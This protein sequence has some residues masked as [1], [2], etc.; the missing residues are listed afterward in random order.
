MALPTTHLQR[1]G[2][3]LEHL[4]SLIAMKIMRITTSKQRDRENAISQAKELS[5]SQ[6]EG[7]SEA[8]YEKSNNWKARNL[9]FSR[10]EQSC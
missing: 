6:W 10:H 3:F 2:R 4:D 7:S 9:D 8:D 5:L 1:S